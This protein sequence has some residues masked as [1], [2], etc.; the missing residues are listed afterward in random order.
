[1][2]R[3]PNYYTKVI[4]EAE[5]L[6][7]IERSIALGKILSDAIDE[8]ALQESRD[9]CAAAHTASLMAI[10]FDT[11]EGDLARQIDFEKTRF[12]IKNN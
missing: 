9:A 6:P 8:G 2:K 5:Q 12:N 7:P 3:R 4:R 1:M 10:I 11:P